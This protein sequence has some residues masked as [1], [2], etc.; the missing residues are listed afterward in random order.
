MGISQRNPNLSAHPLD[1]LQPEMRNV[2]ELV[3]PQTVESVPGLEEG[4]QSRQ[5]AANLLGV[6]ANDGASATAHQAG[7]DAA[8]QELG[9]VALRPAQLPQMAALDAKPLQRRTRQWPALE[10]AKQQKDG[11]QLAGA[12]TN[13]ILK[14]LN[15][16]G[17]FDAGN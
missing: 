2:L 10:C 7:G 5:Q 14:S 12:T 17:S 3:R 9:A 6:G 16:E 8:A 15:Q 13:Q 11:F 1:G 4:A